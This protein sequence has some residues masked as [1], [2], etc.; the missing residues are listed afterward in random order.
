MLN[1][2][3]IPLYST[4]RSLKN[5]GRRVRFTHLLVL[6]REHLK[7]VLTFPRSQLKLFRSRKNK[8]FE[9]IFRM[10]KGV[11]V[12][13]M[14]CS[15]KRFLGRNSQ[16]RG[17]RERERKTYLEADHGFISELLATIT[18]L[19]FLTVVSKDK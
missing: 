10:K 3:N 5:Q 13:S 11:F 4:R 1:Q 2:V 18:N 19:I 7:G 15:C 9:K 17:E 6:Y 14:R 12:N 8:K 16:K